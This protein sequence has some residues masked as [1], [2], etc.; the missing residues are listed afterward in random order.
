MGAGRGR[1]G[2]GPVTVM[3]SAEGAALVLIA[4]Q[5]AHLAVLRAR[6]VHEGA[7]ETRP[8]GRGGRRC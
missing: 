4:W 8:H 1:Q 2:C 7:V 3:S 6:L 5:A